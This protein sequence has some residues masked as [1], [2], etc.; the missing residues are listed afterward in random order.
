MLGEAASAWR[1]GD[2]DEA[3]DLAGASH[4]LVREG[5]RRELA[6]LPLAL[7]LVCGGGG[8]DDV[9]GAVEEALACPFPKL[10]L[11][12]CALLRWITGPEPR[13]DERI[14]ELGRVLLPAARRGRWD[15]L[16]VP[17]EVC[18]T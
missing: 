9:P 17:D 10:A 14:T 4:A 7:W 5:S 12:A 13:L 1:R 11:Q 2:L 6:A 18:L 15:V 8:P 3:R 16:A